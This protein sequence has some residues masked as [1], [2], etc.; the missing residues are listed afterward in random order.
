M[1]ET[2]TN[3]LINATV[4]GIVRHLAGAD[5]DLVNTVK[6]AKSAHSHMLSAFSESLK[7]RVAGHTEDEDAYD[8]MARAYAHIYQYRVEKA[9]GRIHDLTGIDE[10]FAARVIVTMAEE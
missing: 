7:A 1:T 5:R 6:R 8:E 2:T 9:A 3:Q 4:E 10:A